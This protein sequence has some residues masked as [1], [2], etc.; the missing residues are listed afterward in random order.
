MLLP[1]HDEGSPVDLAAVAL[2]HHVPPVELEA[3]VRRLYQHRCQV[4]PLKHCSCRVSHNCLP[5]VS[6]TRRSRKSEGANRRRST[7]AL[8][9]EVMR[10]QVHRWTVEEDEQ[11][12]R[13][14]SRVRRLQRV[15]RT[16][17]VTQSLIYTLWK[18]RELYMFFTVVLQN[19]LVA[20]HS[21][22]LAMQTCPRRRTSRRSTC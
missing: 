12:L 6:V 18:S 17:K 7:K 4:R 16:R 21:R 22:F 8:L 20:P 15:T 9:A 19:H 2:L 13:S 5:F 1:L 11:A 10:K 14:T 3:R